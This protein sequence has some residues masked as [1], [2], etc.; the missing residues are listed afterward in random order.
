[1]VGKSEKRNGRTVGC[2]SHAK[3]LHLLQIV[4]RDI[5][6]YFQGIESHV[7]V[8][9]GSPCIV[10]TRIPVSLSKLGDSAQAKQNCFKRILRY[11][12][13]TSLM[14]GL[15]FSATRARLSNKS[16]KMKMTSHN[17]ALLF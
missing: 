15:M 9:G 10:G 13:K 12:L 8:A 11:A 16:S 17:I 5:N 4:V 3:K 6:D 2:L 7:G 1:M 14:P